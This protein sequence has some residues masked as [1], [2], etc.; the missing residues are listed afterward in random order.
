M[1]REESGSLRAEVDARG[2]KERRWSSE[3]AHLTSELQL[4]HDKIGRLERE[5]AE[6]KAELARVMQLLEHTQREVHVHVLSPMMSFI[7]DYI[8][9]HTH[10]CFRNPPNFLPLS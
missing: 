4:S 5:G 1:T 3:L 2:Q 10:Q 7:I 8:W 6:L 9:K